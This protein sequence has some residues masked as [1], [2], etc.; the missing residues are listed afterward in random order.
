LDG[1]AANRSKVF[2][3]AF[4][5]L[6]NLQ[7]ICPNMRENG[8]RTEI[9]VTQIRRWLQL[10]P[11]TFWDSFGAGLVRQLS[12]PGFAGSRF[13]LPV[14]RPVPDSDDPRR[15]QVSGRLPAGLADDSIPPMLRPIEEAVAAGC[16]LLV[17]LTRSA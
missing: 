9:S 10:R 14:T 4:T 5:V 17:T 13:R 11:V 3:T 16:S 15:S 12:A 7:R 2:V 6:H 8:S 1:R